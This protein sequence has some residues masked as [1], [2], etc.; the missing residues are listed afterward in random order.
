MNKNITL[1]LLCII[2]ILLIIDVIVNLKTQVL[3]GAKGKKYE[4]FD[5]V[6]N[7]EAIANI[8]SLYNSQKLIISNL[9]VT[10]KFNLLPKGIIV[11]WNGTTA[12]TG[13]AICNGSNGTPDLRN[14]FILGYGNKYSLAS[15]GGQEQVTLTRSHMPRHN[16][17]F[18]ARG[19]DEGYCS[20]NNTRSC[21]IKTSDNRSNDR[22][23]SINTSYEGEGKPHNNMPP[24]Y[25]LAFI[26]KL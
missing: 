13:W 5:P 24:Y 20:K 21:G 17:D 22:M 10:N 11:A 25:A 26:M 2:I 15:K 8:A 7:E 12:P 19:D 18:S 16:H 4:S 6:T 3:N 23:P 14:R 9:D 1:I